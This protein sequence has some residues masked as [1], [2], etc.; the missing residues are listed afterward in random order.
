[1]NRNDQFVVYNE[2][3]STLAKGCS[4]KRWGETGV[5]RCCYTHWW[6]TF[7]DCITGRSLERAYFLTNQAKSDLAQHCIRYVYFEWAFFSVCTGQQSLAL[8][9]KWSVKFLLHDATVG[10][11]RGET[12]RKKNVATWRKSHGRG[13][14]WDG[15]QRYDGHQSQLAWNDEEFYS[16]IC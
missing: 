15:H 10:Y 8:G 16:L 12:I 14:L 4:S 7:K 11:G 6:V 13:A 5:H 2:L 3:C 9:W 1:M